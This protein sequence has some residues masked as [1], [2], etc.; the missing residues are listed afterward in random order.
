MAGTEHR[1]GGLFLGADARPAPGWRLGA[2]AGYGQTRLD[3]DG[4]DNRAESDDYHLGLFAGTRLDRL[5]LSLGLGHSRH[6]VDT[7]R[8]SPSTATRAAPAT[9]TTR[10][11]PSCSPKPATASTPARWPWNP[12]PAWPGCA[13]R[14]TATGN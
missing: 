12:S 6:Q 10:P 7:E 11:P 13:T 3:V 2:L 1:A 9:A 5:R 4:G 8:G 14:K